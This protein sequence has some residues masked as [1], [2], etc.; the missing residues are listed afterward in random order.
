MNVAAP[1]EPEIVN[2]RRR[3][4]RAKESRAK[5]LEAATAEFAKHGFDG[6]STREIAKQAGLKHA[7]LIYHFNNKRALWEAVMTEVV[8]LFQKGFSRRLKELEGAD[9]VTRLKSLFGEFIRLAARHPQLHRLMSHEA[10]EGGERI[11]WITQQL[12]VDVSVPFPELIKSAQAQG[13]FVKGDPMHLHYTFL[14]AAARLFMLGGEIELVTGRSPF[15]PDYVEEHV[16]IC[17][18]L[19]FR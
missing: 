4:A 18:D 13:R 11:E 12:L 19:F 3:Q 7:L 1:G 14:G 6:A 17:L 2:T 16:R 8:G 10:W 15:E 9:D 5:I